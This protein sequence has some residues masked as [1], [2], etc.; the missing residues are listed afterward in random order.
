MDNR[1][2]DALEKQASLDNQVSDLTASDVCDWLMLGLFIVF[3]ALC[4]AD[5]V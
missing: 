3:L 5:I 2:F 4:A 1:W